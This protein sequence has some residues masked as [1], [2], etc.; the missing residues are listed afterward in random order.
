MAL[1][2]C[3]APRDRL[4]ELHIPNAFFEGVGCHHQESDHGGRYVRLLWGRGVGLLP[5]EMFQNP[6]A[7]QGGGTYPSLPSEHSKLAKGVIAQLDSQPMLDQGAGEF[8]LH[9]LK[10]LREI[11]GAV[12]IPE[13]GRFLLILEF[14]Y[15]LRFGFFLL[16]HRSHSPSASSVESSFRL[17]HTSGSAKTVDPSPSGIENNEEIPSRFALDHIRQRFHLDLG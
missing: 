17:G 14:G 2:S 7:H 10:L 6:H 13:F 15:A 5:S 4:R 3:G 9:L 16:C 12:G 11:Q 1:P 8:G